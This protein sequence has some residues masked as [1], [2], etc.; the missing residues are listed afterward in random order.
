LNFKAL[1]NG[2]KNNIFLAADANVPLKEYNGEFAHNR[3]WNLVGN[4]YPCYYDTR[5]L[6]YSSPITV[7]NVDRETYNA[8]SP[9][10]DTYVLCPG[11]SFFVQCPKGVEGLGFDKSGRQATSKVRDSEAS[12][13][14]GMAVSQR[15]IVN[16]LIGTSPGAVTDRTRV[17]LNDAA[18]I[19]YEMDK[20]ASKFISTET[21]VPQIYTVSDGV[22]YAI[23]ERPVADG[24]A[25]LAFRAANDGRYAIALASDIEGYRLTL[26]DTYTGHT[27]L[28]T[29]ATPYTFDAKAGTDR[30]RFILH[31]TG[32]TVHISERTAVLPSHL[33]IY[34]TAGVRV[35][36]PS[37][38]G[39]YIQGG[40]KVIINK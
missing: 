24:I 39:L 8:Y 5:F 6:A 19:Q 32:E 29:E 22:D 10:D 34:T 26:E 12:R 31:F 28:L 33:P 1:N 30:S 2:N 13:A 36:S 9:L 23:N 40:K 20:D 35:A 27:A 21:S 14:T 16:L 4:P 17:V 18:S 7:W 15:T 3:S 11:E 25:R 37:R 38:K